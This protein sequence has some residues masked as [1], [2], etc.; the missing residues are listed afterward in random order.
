MA[1]IISLT[2]LRERLRSPSVAEASSVMGGN[3]TGCLVVE[4][5]GGGLDPGP[6]ITQPAC[7]VIGLARNS[8]TVIPAVVD[9]V[10]RSDAHLA[11]LEQAVQSNPR[12]ATVL[13][14]VLRH[15]ERASVVDGL[16]AESLAYSTLQ[17]GAE[18]QRWLAA[19]G[20]RRRPVPDDGDLLLIERDGACLTLTLNLP[21]KRNAFSA[22]MRDALSAAL[23]LPHEDDSI[24]QVVIRGAGPAFCAGGDLDE[25]GS[26]R[27]A[28]LAH[29]TRATRS[30]GRL[31]H[32]LRE[33]VTC[34]V[35]GACIGAGIELPAF[36]GHVVAAEN[37]VFRLPEVAMGL[38]PGAGGTV[39]ITRR[40]GRLRCAEL[41]LSN[42][43]IDA[44]TA[45]AWGLID[46]IDRA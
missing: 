46:R 26:A 18:F 34:R 6:A 1:Q 39:S 33:R 14:Q 43:P 17:H 42:Q 45:L 19:R 10:A 23:A 8:A 31:I 21:H 32:E 7:P 13:M 27:D 35:H 12:A 24:E 20:D 29:L 3:D 5:D 16:L 41:A 9:V 40:V 15:N 38:I 37:A 2:E 36:A 25:F 30:P 28:T 11:E 44:P 22:P 4:L